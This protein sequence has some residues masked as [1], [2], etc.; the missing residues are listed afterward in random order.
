MSESFV[1]KTFE[2]VLDAKILECR[3]LMLRKEHDY[4]PRNISSRGTIG[5]A[6]R[7]NDKSERLW[8][9]LTKARAPSNESLRDTFM[10]LANYG[11]IGMMLLDGEW[12]L[13]ME[14]ELSKGV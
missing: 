10:D 11:L 5:L 4:G 2:E 9:L 14:E 6:V 13:P 3:E 12:G 8:N 1:P 7:I